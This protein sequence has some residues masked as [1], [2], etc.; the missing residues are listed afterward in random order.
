MNDQR[1]D[2]LQ[3]QRC[4]WRTER[5]HRHNRLWS[6]TR[7]AQLRG[8][9]TVP[10][11]LSLL[12]SLSLSLFLIKMALLISVLFQVATA[13]EETVTVIRRSKVEGMMAGM[14]IGDVYGYAKLLGKA[15]ERPDARQIAEAA[16]LMGNRVA[17]PSQ[18]STEAET[19]GAA[20]WGSY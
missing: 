16:L 9:A 5:L 8:G 18:P 15:N 19:G 6:L 7:A 3:G 4:W 17:P 11:L 13:L 2:S 14:E 20:P 1:R 10:I 12:L